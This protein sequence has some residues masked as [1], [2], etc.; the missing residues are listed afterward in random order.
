MPRL[1][2]SYSLLSSKLKAFLRLDAG[3]GREIPPERV[4]ERVPERDQG[5]QVQ[6]LQKRMKAAEARAG[7]YKQ[8][9]DFLLK[10]AF[11]RYGP[12]ITGVEIDGHV[13][14]SSTRHDNPKPAE[15]AC[16]CPEASAGRVL[17]TGSLE[18]ALTLELA[19]RASEVVGLEAR[20]E[21][22][23]RA[24]FLKRLFGVDNISFHVANLEQEDLSAYGR[25]DAI[26]C[27]GLLYHLPH[28]RTFVERMASVSDNLYLDTHFASEDW[29][30]TERD[31]LRGWLFSEGGWDQPQSGVS[32]DSFW[33]TL[34][35]L[36]RLLTES[37]Y[38]SLE[39][40]SLHPNNRNGP[41][42]HI[43][44]TR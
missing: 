5:K 2:T 12:W 32:E 27:C 39:R 7:Q 6:A 14:G 34:T 36:E 4:P 8:T 17:E 42:V 41:R 11:E 25:F 37:G 43:R 21:S 28:P 26:F 18:G 24:E 15:F 22:V 40:L 23:Q 16:A 19:K 13:Y 35:E 44:A 20:P 10:D 9:R 1:Q 31:G 33:P 30:L 3:I 29:M 38:T